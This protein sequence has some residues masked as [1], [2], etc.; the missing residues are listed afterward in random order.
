MQYPSVKVHSYLPQPSQR[1]PETSLSD[2][3]KLR[4]KS[5]HTISLALL[6]SSVHSPFH[7]ELLLLLKIGLLRLC[8]FT[9]REVGLEE[10]EPGPGKEE[11][12]KNNVFSFLKGNTSSK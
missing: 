1:C 9:A 7:H 5:P 3:N 8:W 11:R 12:K 10:D 4:G 2:I 6:L